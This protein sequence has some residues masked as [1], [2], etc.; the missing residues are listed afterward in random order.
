MKHGPEG[1]SL[2]ITS[3]AGKG[4]YGEIERELGIEEKEAR[5]LFPGVL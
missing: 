2:L 5:E 4:F 3:D 1:S